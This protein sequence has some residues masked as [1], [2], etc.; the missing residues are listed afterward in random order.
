MKKLSKRMYVI[1]FVVL[2]CMSLGSWW[3]VSTKDERE[4]KTRFEQR[5]K[6]AERQRVEI[7]IIEQTVQLSRLHRA[8][9]EKTIWQEQGKFCTAKKEVKQNGSE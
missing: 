6:F 9:V 5:I 4:S 7:D 2:N 8:I 1:I 3:Y